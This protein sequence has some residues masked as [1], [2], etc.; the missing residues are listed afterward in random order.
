MDAAAIKRVRYIDDSNEQTPLIFNNAF[1]HS[2]NIAAAQVPSSGDLTKWSGGG[3]ASKSQL[4]A[5][6]RYKAN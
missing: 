4:A 2:N 1:G 5:I 3:N 6:L